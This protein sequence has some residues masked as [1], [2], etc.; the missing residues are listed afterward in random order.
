MALIISSVFYNLPQTTSSFQRRGVLLFFAILLAAFASML[1]IL[2]LYAQR[3]IVDKHA[4]YAFYHPSAEAFASMLCDM[5]YK[6]S[7]SILFSLTLYFMTNLRREPGPYFFFLLITFTLTMVM[8]MIFRTIAASSRT[9]TQALCPAALLI[10][11]L[12]IFTGYVI[13]T[14]D[15]LGWCRWINYLD[16]ISYGFEALM[17]NEFHNQN[18][19]CDSFV[20][21]GPGY[22]GASGLNIVCSSVGSVAGSSIVNGDDYINTAYQS[23]HSHKWRNFGKLKAFYHVSLERC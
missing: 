8:S 2:T 3:P 13:P 21:S 11:G 12:V 17:V 4:R 1:E 10:L 18:Y 5:P 16:P 7:N 22:E 20:P 14:P 9:L 15:M 19:Q 6:I 23:Y